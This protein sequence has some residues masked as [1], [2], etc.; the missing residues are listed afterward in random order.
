MKKKVK[1][2]IFSLQNLHATSYKQ[3]ISYPTIQ[4][5]VQCYVTI[6]LAVIIYTND[7]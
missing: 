5:V 6:K 3:Q 4:K 7:N 1:R 2:Y